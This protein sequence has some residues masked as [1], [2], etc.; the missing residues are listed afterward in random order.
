MNLAFCIG[1]GESRSKLNLEKLKDVGPIYGCNQLIETFDLDNTI[2]VDKSLLID[3]LARGINK[4]TNLY[5]RNRWKSTVQAD[6]L[7]F[8]DDPIKEPIH[9]WDNEIHWGSGVHALNLAAKNNAEVVV[10]LGYD[11][12]DKSIY[13]EQTVD[14]ACWIYQI[15]KCFD[16]HHTVEFVQIQ[17]EGWVCPPEWDRSNFSLDT[18]SSLNKIIKEMR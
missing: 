6:N 18:F 7:H 17:K 8:L 14:P 4:K 10:M 13:N 15:K 9:R 5:T 2:V 11:L 16:M 3:F 1:N 12:Y